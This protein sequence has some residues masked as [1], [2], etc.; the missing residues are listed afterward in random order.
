MKSDSP[1]TPSSNNKNYLLKPFSVGTMS[2]VLHMCSQQ[3]YEV[4]MVSSFTDKENVVH[5][6]IKQLPKGTQ[7]KS[8]GVRM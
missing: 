3:C 7:I 1:R 6:V 8:D 2:S 5:R 4:G